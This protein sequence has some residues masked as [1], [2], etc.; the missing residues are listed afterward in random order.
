M[1]IIFPL[2]HFF[3]DQTVCFRGLRSGGQYLGGLNLDSLSPSGSGLDSLISDGLSFDS[4][5]RSK[6]MRSMLK[7][8]SC[9]Q[10]AGF[11]LFEIG[12]LSYNYIFS[13]RP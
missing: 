7:R 1:D 8:I 2:F 6:A 11:D 3:S 10:P 13:L 4:L 5:R 12:G 9:F